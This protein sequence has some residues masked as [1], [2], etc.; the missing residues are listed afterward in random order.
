MKII[1]GLGNP[2]A[3]YAHTKHIVGFMLVDALAEELGIDAWR[4]KF[5][6]LVAEGRIGAEKVLLVKPLTYMNESGRA[7]APLLD[8]Y[9]LAPEELIVVHDDMDIAVGT[10]RLRRKGS[11]GG[12]NGIKSLLAHIGSQEFSRVRIGIGRPLPGWT[13][14][15]HVLAPFSAEDGSKVHEAIAYLLPAVECIV[16][17]GMDMAMNRYNPRKKKAAKQEA[18]ERKSAEK[19]SAVPQVERQEGEA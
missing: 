7:L 5:N 11:A 2:G 17:D 19:S 18:Q 3:E 12:H 8:W 13:V 16:T 9:K 15:R 10:I 4:E 1:A 6:A 14:V